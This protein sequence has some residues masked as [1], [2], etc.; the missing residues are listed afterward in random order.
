MPADFADG[1][2]DLLEP[3]AAGKGHVTQATL[4]RVLGK[5]GRL[6]YLVPAVRPFV[7]ALWG[8]L[9]GSRAAQAAGRREAP[10]DRHAARRFAPASRWLR[11]LL[12]P[13]GASETLLPLEQVV[14]LALP[15]IT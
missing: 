10:P 14:V 9:A 5:C 13:P 12:R 3:L 8:A 15:A 1:L 2:H 11:T 7:G 4:D 6:A